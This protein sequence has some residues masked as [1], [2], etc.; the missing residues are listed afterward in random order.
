MAMTYFR[1]VIQI[2]VI[3][4]HISRRRNLAVDLRGR[5]RALV[6]VCC[7]HGPLRTLFDSRVG[8][9]VRSCRVDERLRLLLPI[10]RGVVQPLPQIGLCLG[11]SAS[12]LRSSVASF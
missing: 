5:D 1:R 6:A 7:T 12:V 10:A 4:R 2:N 8:D 3:D 9:A 11:K